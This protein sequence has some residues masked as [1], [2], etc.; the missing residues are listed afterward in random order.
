M[1]KMSPEYLY[2]TIKKNIYILLMRSVTIAYIVFV[3]SID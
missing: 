3:F 1:S 2:S